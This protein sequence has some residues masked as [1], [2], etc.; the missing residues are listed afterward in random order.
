M[1]GR[2]S[3]TDAFVVQKQAE[4]QRSTP[5]RPY[6]EENRLSRKSKIRCRP[7]SNVRLIHTLTANKQ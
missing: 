6:Y 4:G 1:V 2:K 7:G 5:A 3:Q